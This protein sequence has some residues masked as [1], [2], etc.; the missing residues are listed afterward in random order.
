MVRLTD[1]LSQVL[2]DIEEDEADTVQPLDTYDEHS[3]A[4]R[5]LVA[6]SAKNQNK[7]DRGVKKRAKHLAR[8]A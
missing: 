8:N 6:S 7:A 3:P 2:A 5:Y 4:F 1:P